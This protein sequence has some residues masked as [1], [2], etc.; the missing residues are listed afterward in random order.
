MNGI[1][2]GIIFVLLGVGVF[3]FMRRRA[4]KK[5]EEEE[6]AKAAAA[7]AAAAAATAA[8]AAA[9]EEEEEEEEEEDEEE[10]EE[11]EEESIE[12]KKRAI[13]AKFKAYKPTPRATPEQATDIFFGIADGNND[14]VLDENELSLIPDKMRKDFMMMDYL[15]GL[16]VLKD[17]ILSK[18]EMTNLMK[19]MNNAARSTGVRLDA[20]RIE[21]GVDY[22]GNDIFHYHPKSNPKA[23]QSVC[24]KKCNDMSNCKLVTFNNA[25]TLCWGKSRAANK[26]PRGDRNNY[27]KK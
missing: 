26:K 21:N 20:W 18:Q 12:D 3:L 22:P 23:N 24:L 10:E 4:A 1:V 5:K 27:F 19:K 6:E 16:G 2:I 15:S 25:K 8:A 14:D 11:E 9:E 7:A 13:E 17:K